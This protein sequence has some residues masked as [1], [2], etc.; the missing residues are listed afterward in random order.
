MAAIQPSPE[1]HD[2]VVIGSGAG[3]GTVAHVLTALGVQVTLLEAGPMLDPYRDFKE[4][5]WPYDVGHRGA[6]VG[7][8]RYTDPRSRSYFSTVSG[9]WELEGEPYTVGDG[10]EFQ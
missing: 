2:V 10:S 6:N 9:G 8:S 7:G 3:G 5:Q 4:H 1:I